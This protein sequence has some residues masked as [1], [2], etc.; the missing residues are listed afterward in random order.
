MGTIDKIL[1]TGAT[2][3][4]GSQILQKLLSAGYTPVILI[5]P[6]SNIWRIKSIIS[7]CEVFTLDKDGENIKELFDLHNITSI[8]H[9]ATEYGREKPL[10]ALLKTNVI[11]PIQLIENGLNKDLKLFINADTFFAKPQFEQDYLN[12]YTDSKRILEGLLKGLSALVAIRNV[13]LE[14]IFGEN[15]S[16]SKF[17]TAILNK[18][19]RNEAEI[20]LTDGSQKRDFVYIEDAAE[21]FV[22]ILQNADHS[23]GYLEFQVGRGQSISVRSF[24]EEMA[25]LT[26]SRST[27]KFGAMQNRI[28]E[29]SDSFADLSELTKIG[30]KPRYDVCS[31]IT[32]MITLTKQVENEY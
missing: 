23:N 7:Q 26:R 2:G 6:T 32:N 18:L 1:V 20:L 31:A 22:Q 16:E 12:Q 19:M 27:L 8:I 21:A 4:L 29:I 25:S 5:R 15:D 13:R 30:W 11:F 3:F 14:H 17:V 10:S 9:T 28:G 24:V